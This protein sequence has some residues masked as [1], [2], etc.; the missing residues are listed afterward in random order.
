MIDV[1]SML[2]TELKKDTF[3]ISYFHT[4]YPIKTKSKQKSVY[5]WRKRRANLTGQIFS[6]KKPRS[7]F[8]SIKWLGVGLAL[9]TFGTSS[10]NQK[11]LKIGFQKAEIPS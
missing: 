9:M 3:D 4:A 5:L 8:W 10:Q 2:V 1:N 7:Y 6:L 11:K